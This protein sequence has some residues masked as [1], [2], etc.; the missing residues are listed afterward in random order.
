MADLTSHVRRAYPTLLRVVPIAGFALAVWAT[1]PAIAARLAGPAPKTWCV[2]A[3]GTYTQSGPCSN[4]AQITDI[5][6]AIT[7]AFTGG[8]STA[9]IEVDAPGEVYQAPFG[10]YSIPQ[11]KSLTIE[12]GFAGGAS[13]T[14]WTVSGTNGST[15]IAADSSGGDVCF[16]VPVSTTLN[17]YEFNLDCGSMLNSGTVAVPAGN[18]I[19]SFITGTIGGTYNLASGATMEI[20]DFSTSGPGLILAGGTTIT[21]G[22]VKVDNGSGGSIGIGQ[23]STDQ[24]SIDNLELD[25]SAAIQGPGTLTINKS[26]T[27][28]GGTLGASDGTYVRSFFVLGPGGTASFASVGGPESLSLVA[29][30]LTLNGPTTDSNAAGSNL[31]MSSTAAGSSTLINNAAFTFT[32]DSS[33]GLSSDQFEAISAGSG[34]SFVKICCA[35][36][37]SS[38]GVPIGGST[39]VTVDAGTLSFTSGLTQTTGASTVASGATLALGSGQTLTLN[40]GSLVIDGTLTGNLDNASGAVSLGSTPGKAS[41]SGTYAQGSAASLSLKVGGSNAG[42]QY[43]QL[44]VGGAATLAGTLNLS[45]IDGFV[46]ANGE[47]FAALT[48]ASRSGAFGSVVQTRVDGGVLT[49][50][51][52][53]T[54]VNLVASEYSATPTP[55]ASPTPTATPTPGGLWHHVYVPLVSNG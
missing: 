9:N 40:G 38:L 25:D 31:S 17:I 34:G 7:Q 27:W 24:V 50:S 18:L 13:S 36:G 32:D 21:G 15:F 45:L 4:S 8:A 44:A 12:G 19:F 3:T 39:A 11:G 49:P 42:T 2:Q 26:F 23:A 43:D 10:G 16:D 54:G 20:W 14:A 28:N 48:S 46:P 5:Q 55:T 35:G 33:V 6:S 47:S 22:L 29:T 37:T 41:I 51:Y 1:A 52:M 53:S 30:T